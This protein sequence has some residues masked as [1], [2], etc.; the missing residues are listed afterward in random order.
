MTIKTALEISITI[1]SQSDRPDKDEISRALQ[2]C[3]DTL[4]TMQWTKELV[5]DACDQFILDNQRDITTHD[6]DY[7]LLPRHT[8]IRRL[9]GMT[10]AE[11]RDRYYPLSPRVHSIR[12]PYRNIDE[13][14]VVQLFID[15]FHRV[16]PVS[17]QDFVERY[18][19]SKSPCWQTVACY[20]DMPQQWSRLLD[21]LGLRL[22]PKSKKKNARVPAKLTVTSNSALLEKCKKH[23]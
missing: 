21:Y 5:F 16:K 13:R 10:A 7:A 6:F 20:C 8:T 15:E 17:Q 22:Y 12:S 3:H 2:I 11:F 18:D 1:I 9:F 4:H 14:D 19:N 23:Y